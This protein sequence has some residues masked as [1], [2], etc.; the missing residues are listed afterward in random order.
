MRFYQVIMYFHIRDTRTTC[1]VLRSVSVLTFTST[2]LAHRV[3]IFTHV[4]LSTRFLQLN[5]RPWKFTVQM[6][7]ENKIHLHAHIFNIQ[8]IFSFAETNAAILKLISPRTTY[9]IGSSSRS[10]CLHTGISP[11]YRRYSCRCKHRWKG[12]DN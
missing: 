9:C 10:T 12:R 11:C 2:L 8:D 6:T 3:M 4:F 5:C 7:L 1:F